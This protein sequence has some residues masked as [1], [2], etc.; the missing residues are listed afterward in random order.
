MFPGH[1]IIRAIF[2]CRSSSMECNLWLY[3]LQF[4]T[5]EYVV[6]FGEGGKG[7]YIS[8]DSYMVLQCSLQVV[9]NIDFRFE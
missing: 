5:S 3:S 4:L 8:R 6:S 2:P 7:S 9:S 1:S